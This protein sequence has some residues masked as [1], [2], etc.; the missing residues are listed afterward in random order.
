VLD[1]CWLDGLIVDRNGWAMECGSEN[2]VFRREMSWSRDSLSLDEEGARMD[3]R[4][5]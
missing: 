1:S 5:T 4:I 3:Q 2:F